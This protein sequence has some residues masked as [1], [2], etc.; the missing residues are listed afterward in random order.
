MRFLSVLLLLAFTVSVVQA[1]TFM[2]TNNP[3]GSKVCPENLNN[4]YETTPAA[5]EQ[6]KETAKKVKKSRWWQVKE[7]TQNIPQPQQPK[8]AEDSGF[9]ILK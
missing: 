8:R 4:I 1:E 3:F 6:D 5:M 9:I 7:D 2:P